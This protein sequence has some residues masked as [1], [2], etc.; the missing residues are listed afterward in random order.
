[1]A[2]SPPTSFSVTDSVKIGF[3]QDGSGWLLVTGKGTLFRTNDYGSHWQSLPLPEFDGLV[4]AA[5]FASRSLGL[6]GGGLFVSTSNPEAPNY[7]TKGDAVHGWAVL[8][9]V[10]LMTSDSGVTWSLRRLPACAYA[11]TE[12]KLWNSKDGYAFGDNCFFYTSDG[13]HSWRVGK[14]PP[15]L[16][17]KEDAIGLLYQF[18]KG[19]GWMTFSDR[20]LFKTTDGGKH[21]RLLASGVP[22][23]G[24]SMEFATKLLGVGLSGGE[25]YLTKDGGA[26]WRRIDTGVRLRS[27]ATS[28]RMIWAVADDTLYR[29]KGI[30]E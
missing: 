9:P 22:F 18:D 13:G 10:V 19:E 2:V 11:I 29:I 4:G 21:W 8:T 14:F 16:Y 5:W 26:A 25:L 12:V 1:M 6:L 7:A 24:H 15:G 28:D 20:S 17:P 27:V 3:A 23:F 30:G